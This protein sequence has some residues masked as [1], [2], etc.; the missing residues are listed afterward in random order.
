MTEQLIRCEHCTKPVMSLTDDGQIII[1][2]R[3]HSEWHETAFNLHDLIGTIKPTE[4]E[5]LKIARG[6]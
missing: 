2:A 4:I 6:H 5:I 3:H 1:R